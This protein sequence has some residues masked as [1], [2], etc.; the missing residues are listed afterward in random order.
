MSMR[1]PPSGCSQC[2]N[3]EQPYQHNL[4]Q[5]GQD[6]ETQILLPSPAVAGGI[7]NLIPQMCQ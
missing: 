2:T 5:T 4:Q 3:A 6:Q 7:C 1:D